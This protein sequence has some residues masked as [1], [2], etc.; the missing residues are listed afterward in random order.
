MV[1]ILSLGDL[2]DMDGRRAGPEPS[3][4]DSPFADLLVCEV[5]KITR[6]TH[7]TAR[8]AVCFE[9]WCCRGL[10]TRDIADALS[11]SQST[12]NQH[13]RAALTK[14]GRYQYAGLLT[15]MVEE[16]GWQAVRDAILSAR[17]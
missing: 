17:K 9:W 5:R 13:L 2:P 15:V 11:I 8:Q 3:C 4:R 7:M 1:V 16:F 10:S 6:R 12:A 14:A